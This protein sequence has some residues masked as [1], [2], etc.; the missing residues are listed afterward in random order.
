MHP[1]AEGRVDRIQAARTRKSKRA[2]GREGSGAQERE[3]RKRKQ[4]IQRNKEG[5]AFINCTV[6]RQYGN[7]KMQPAF[8]K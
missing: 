8:Q 5:G 2:K 4:Q 7:K 3:R 6:L 1:L